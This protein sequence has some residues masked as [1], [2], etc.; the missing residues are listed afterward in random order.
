[1]ENREFIPATEL[2][3][4]VGDDV[5]VICLENGELKQKPGASI[6]GEVCDM[7]IRYNFND[8]SYEI[9]HGTYDKVVNKII[10]DV[11]PVVYCIKI[12]NLC[13]S[14]G[15]VYVEY[16]DAENKIMLSADGLIFNVYADNR[17][18]ITD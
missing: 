6:G 17:I 18:E 4:A 14:I 16:F 9:I 2:P 1:M 3:E 5:S 7:K 13:K 10:N 12:R 15:T 8:N 11:Y